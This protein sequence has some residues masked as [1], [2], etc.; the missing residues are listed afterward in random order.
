MR[1][2]HSAYKVFGLRESRLAIPSVGFLSYPS[3]MTSYEFCNDLIFV[4]L[5]DALTYAQRY[6]S[7]FPWCICRY[8]EFPDNCIARSACED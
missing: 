6:C 7:D 4:S 3:Y 8:G 5:E 2:L 1:S